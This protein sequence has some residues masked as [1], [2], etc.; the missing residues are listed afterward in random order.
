MVAMELSCEPRI[1]AHVRRLYEGSS[2]SQ[3]G[4]S[5]SSSSS[6][7]RDRRRG[8]SGATLT[9]APTPQGKSE[10]DLFHRFHGLQHLSQ[11]PAM[12]VVEEA[13]AAAWT[14]EA[15]GEEKE[16]ALEGAPRSAAAEAAASSAQSGEHDQT[17]D[18]R[19]MAGHAQQRQTLWLR[20]QQ[21]KQAGLVTYSLDP[22]KSSLPG[23]DLD[24]YGHFRAPF[25]NAGALAAASAAAASKKGG[26]DQ[27]EDELEASIRAD[28]VDAWNGERLQVLDDA[29]AQRLLPALKSGLEKKLRDS[30]RAAVVHGASAKLRHQFLNVGPFVPRSV[31]QN[32]YAEAL[33]SRAGAG[34]ARVVGVCVSDDKR[35]GDAL[36]ALTE[37]GAVITTIIEENS[38]ER[39]IYVAVFMWRPTSR[40]FLSSLIKTLHK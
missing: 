4:S 14:N 26:N 12:L 18:V 30:S 5:S 22:P 23:A 24:P 13:D 29:I 21:A 27:E 1:R 38:R 34:G 25:E 16:A 3:S 35:F 8:N 20:L 36:V 33:T 39:D 9:T 10:L 11:K 15:D 2:S 7:L 28:V 31:R 40:S 37:Q 6:S 19:G 32:N 17:N